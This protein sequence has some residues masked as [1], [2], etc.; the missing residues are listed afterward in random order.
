[1][2]SLE[3]RFTT[4]LSSVIGLWM[5]GLFLILHVSTLYADELAGVLMA[6]E[7]LF[8]ESRIVHFECLEKYDFS[9]L[10]ARLQ[11]LSGVHDVIL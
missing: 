11:D 1:M 10:V 9:S 2:N 3:R 5:L 4:V 8:F 6:P 7:P